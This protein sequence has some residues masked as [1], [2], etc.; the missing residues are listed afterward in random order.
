MKKQRTRFPTSLKWHRTEL[1]SMTFYS[2]HY[3]ITRPIFY[4]SNTQQILDCNKLGRIYLKPDRDNSTAD[5]MLWNIR[6]NLFTFQTQI[7]VIE[8]PFKCRRKYLLKISD[9]TSLNISL[10]QR[11]C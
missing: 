9:K 4:Y 1:N 7:R 6:T 5:G 2:V 3:I 11:V 8:M 10:H